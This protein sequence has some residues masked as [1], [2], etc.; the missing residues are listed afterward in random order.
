MEDDKM[1]KKMSFMDR[2]RFLFSGNNP[3]VDQMGGRIVELEAEV[4]ELKAE[5]DA[6]LE[7]ERLKE[8]KVKEEKAREA[9]LQEEKIRDEKVSKLRNDESNTEKGNSDD[10]S[11][12]NYLR[13]QLMAE[14]LK[15]DD[16]LEQMDIMGGSNAD[17]L[18]SIQQYQAKVLGILYAYTEYDTKSGPDVV[19]MFQDKV[20]GEAM[21]MDHDS[22]RAFIDGY[23]HTRF[24]SCHYDDRDWEQYVNNPFFDGREL[25]TPI[26]DGRARSGYYSERTSFKTISSRLP[27]LFLDYDERP[28]KDY[29]PS[30]IGEMVQTAK[31]VAGYGVKE[32]FEPKK[33][34]E[35]R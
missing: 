25:K 22:R 16:A 20:R 1:P 32:I 11:L 35:G 14:K 34:D 2:L 29:E 17:K 27:R 21:K 5:K 18:K 8:E 31:D 23:M 9:K 33:D 10:I 30:K 7:V 28:Q 6:G 4:A 19:A 12:S 15:L 3:V 13:E 26:T 24:Q